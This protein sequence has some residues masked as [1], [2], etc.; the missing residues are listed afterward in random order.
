MLGGCIDNE[1]VEKEKDYGSI[2]AIK[3]EQIDLNSIFRPI[4]SSIKVTWSSMLEKVATVNSDGV[5]T[6]LIIG[7][8]IIIRTSEN[9]LIDKIAITIMDERGPHII[10]NDFLRVRI[11]SN[12]EYNQY[13]RDYYYT[14]KKNYDFQDAW[15]E[16]VAYKIVY[17]EVME[18]YK[19]EFIS[20][21]YPLLERYSR[22]N[23]I[24]F[25]I[26][27]VLYDIYVEYDQIVLSTCPYHVKVY[28]NKGVLENVNVDM[29]MD[30]YPDMKKFNNGLA[31]KD[32]I[33]HIKEF[34]D[35][36]IDVNNSILFK[37]LREYEYLIDIDL[38][39]KDGTTV[40]ELTNIFNETLSMK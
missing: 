13:M 19:Q 33:V 8:T 35:M 16:D 14:P 30:Q 34:L 38:T 26:S 3:G 36:G 31:I 37:K 2:S 27:K 10:D 40:E 22:G 1:V 21:N 24:S 4:D 15:L 29:I 23:I 5:V 32:N 17:V 20:K 7:K 25:A 39:I 11:L 12:E 18:Y 9:N 6:G 28:N